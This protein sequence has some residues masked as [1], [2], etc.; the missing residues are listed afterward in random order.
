MSKVNTAR[1]ITRPSHA[2]DKKVSFVQ[3][4]GKMYE[5]VLRDGKLQ[6]AARTSGGQWHY[7]RET[8]EKFAPMEWLDGLAQK[9]VVLLPS[10]VQPGDTIDA[11]AKAIRIHIHRYFDCPRQFESVEVLYVLMTWLTECFQ[12]VP[13]L[14]FLGLP[15]TG[16]S[17]GSDVIG[18]VCYRRLALAGAATAAPMYHLIESV[19]GTLFID[20]ADFSSTDVGS[21]IAKILNCGYQRGKA[22]LRMTKGQ[23]EHLEPGAYDVFGPKILNGRTKFRDEATESRCLTY[24]TRETERTDIPVQLPPEFDAEAQVLRNK[25]LAFRYDYLEQIKFKNH[26]IPGIG[27][28]TNEIVLPLFLIAEQLQDRVYT[29]ELLEFSKGIEV[30]LRQERRESVEAILVEGFVRL[31]AGGAE[32]TCG[33]VKAHMVGEL[34]QD[35]PESKA[36][37]PKRVGSLARA[38]GF[39]TARTNRGAVLRIERKRLTALCERFNIVTQTSL[40]SSLRRDAGDDEVTVENA[41]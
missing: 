31:S 32:P 18:S 2:R 17:R 1:M 22:V 25:L 10:A 8:A 12:A 37:S 15:G 6:F 27:R 3:F 14:R 30:G 38:I 33:E 28:R 5:L 7:S 13:Y 29:S 11:L 16:K 41:A 21:E 9:G 40:D 36:L 4:G 19:G 23:N 39:T 24:V 26:H 20:E 34:G 35:E